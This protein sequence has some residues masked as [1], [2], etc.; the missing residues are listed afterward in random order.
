MEEAGV[1]LTDG[2]PFG[3]GIEGHVRFNFA[4]FE[5]IL[6]EI[7]EKMAAALAR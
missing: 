3:S 6:I 7:I 5:P 4:T 1:A 2:A